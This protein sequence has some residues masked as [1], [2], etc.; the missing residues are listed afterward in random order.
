MTIYN[1]FPWRGA[2]KFCI[3]FLLK[4]NLA[5]LPSPKKEEKVEFP[6]SPLNVGFVRLI[7]NEI[8]SDSVYHGTIW[9]EAAGTTNANKNTYSSWHCSHT[10]LFTPFTHDSS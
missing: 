6:A 2:A 4:N 10:R 3:H 8:Q 9:K 5:L 7:E 1:F